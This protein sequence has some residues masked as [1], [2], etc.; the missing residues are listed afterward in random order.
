VGFLVSDSQIR[1]IE[2][3]TTQ[4][5]Q[6]SFYSK[7]K[8]SFIVGVINTLVYMPPD[9]IKTHLQKHNSLSNESLFHTVTSVYKKNGWRGFYMGWQVRLIHYM[10]QSVYFSYL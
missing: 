4:T 5:D 6:L 3:E 10:M 9:T 7:I 2:K 1:N 8:V